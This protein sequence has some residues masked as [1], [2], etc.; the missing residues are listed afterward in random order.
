MAPSASVAHGS[1]DVFDNAFNPWIDISRD[2]N[3]RDDPIDTVDSALMAPDGNILNLVEVDDDTKHN[4]IA[5]SV[6][7]HVVFRCDL[8]YSLAAGSAGYAKNDDITFAAD[9][10]TRYTIMT[11]ATGQKWSGK[12]LAR[13]M[14]VGVSGS[15]FPV[16]GGDD[17]LG[18]IQDV[19][20]TWRLKN[21]GKAFVSPYA[22]LDLASTFE[23]KSQDL[24]TVF[25]LDGS[26]WL[27]DE[28]GVSYPL[29]R[30]DGLWQLYFVFHLMMALLP[31]F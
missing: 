8:S 3:F 4:T 6:L 1:F 24:G 25:E 28:D 9:S 30:K 13:M 2:N 20:G 29:Y 18:Y 16:F 15:P 17:M 31:I 5:E 10:G 7:S 23:M 11:M 22:N 19:S 26:A 21:F 27:V 14:F 12:A